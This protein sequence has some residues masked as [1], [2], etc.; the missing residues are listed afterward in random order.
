MKNI[1]AQELAKQIAKD[2]ADWIDGVM[3]KLVPPSLHRFIT[4]E[5]SDS[6]RLHPR[7]KQ[8]LHENRIQIAWVHD[9]RI[10]C[11]RIIVNGQPLCEW[12][13]SMSIDGRPVDVEKVLAHAGVWV[14]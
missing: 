8:F 12:K 5:G 3:R 2:Q 11:P 14:E 13:F 1:E 9:H 6:K 4:A 10:P 7:L